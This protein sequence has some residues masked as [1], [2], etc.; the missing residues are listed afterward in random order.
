MGVSTF[1]LL[2]EMVEE[3]G[4]APDGAGGFCEVSAEVRELV[5]GDKTGWLESMESGELT[6]DGFHCEMITERITPPQAPARFHN[7][8]YHVPTGDPGVTPSFPP[9]RSEFDEFRWWR[10]SDLIASWEANELRLPPPIVTLTRDLVEAIEREGDLQSACD[11]LAADPPSGPHRFEYGPGVEC[12]L[13]RT[14]TLPPATHTNCFIL[15]ERGGERVIVDPASRDEEGLEELALKVQEIHDDGSSI[16]ATI[17]T[18]RHP[19]HVGDLTR[20][21]EIYQAPIWASQ[22]TLASIAPCEN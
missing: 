16:T 5:C 9:G 4:V 19:D 10:P 11:A 2:R 20:I 8:F 14:A 15:G 21:S 3:L 18:H 7:L 1:A 22:E 6:A 12:I 13:I 17:F